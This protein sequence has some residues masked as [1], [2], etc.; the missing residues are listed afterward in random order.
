MTCKS[1]WIREPL[2]HFCVLGAAIFAI[3]AVLKPAGAG[4]KVIIVEPGVERELTD[5]FQQMT[6]RP[7]TS[8]ELS[9]LIE[10]W[11][12][13]EILYR[14]GLALGLDKGDPAIRERVVL[15]M[16]S[17]ARMQAVVDAPPEAELRNWF[18]AHRGDYDQPTRYDFVEIQ[19]P[20][21]SDAGGIEAEKLRTALAGGTDPLLL[22]YMPTPSPR[23]KPDQIRAAFGNEFVP[24]LEEQTPGEWRVIRTGKIWHVIG[25]NAVDPPQQ[26]DFE[27]LRSDLEEDWRR[28][29]QLRLAAR[30]IKGMRANYEVRRAGG[31]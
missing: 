17:N 18:E 4:E 27:T 13:S 22:G 28:E 25:L 2:V 8:E 23:L 15:N 20:D 29:Q 14:E 24:Q 31:G 19:L 1:S 26:A 16:K 21:D 12:Q 6:Q 9:N 5:R 3:Y 11:V 10:G 30:L 7:P